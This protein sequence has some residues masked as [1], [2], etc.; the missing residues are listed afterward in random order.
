MLVSALLSFFACNFYVLPLMCA[1]S[2]WLFG[3]FQPFDVAISTAGLMVPK[4]FFFVACIPTSI[5]LCTELYVDAY[6]FNA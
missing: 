6:K 3:M 5:L 2:V 1:F 4:T